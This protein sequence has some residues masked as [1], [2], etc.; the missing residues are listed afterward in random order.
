MPAALQAMR[1]L[2]N[3]AETGAVTLAFP[4]DVQAEAYDFPEA[5]FAQAC[6]ARR[7]AAAGRGGAASTRRR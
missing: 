5:F 3:Q 2:V 6:V 1:V 4:Q 7:A